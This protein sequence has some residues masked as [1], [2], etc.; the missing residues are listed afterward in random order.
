[1]NYIKQIQEERK[2]LDILLF[3]RQE[4]VQELKEYLT[5][6][7]FNRDQSDGSRGDLVAV[8]D[9]LRW[10]TYIESPTN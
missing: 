5:G 10:L 1:M 4:R 3:T 6:S 9:I 2:E 8:A 7:K